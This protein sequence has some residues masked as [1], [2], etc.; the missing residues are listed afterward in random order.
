MAIKLNFEKKI[1]T[2]A[3][4]VYFAFTKKMGLREWIAD[5]VE[6]NEGR[7]NSFVL[8]WVDGNSVFGTIVEK[9]ENEKI[10]FEALTAE[11][12]KK[13]DVEILIEKKDDYTILKSEVKGVQEK[14]QDKVET[15]FEN[16]FENLRSVLEDGKDLRVYKKPM[17]GINIGELINPESAKR[18]N[19]PVE[20]GVVIPALV[21]GLG[22]KAAGIK[23][24]DII[25]EINET[26][27]IAYEDFSELAKAELGDV[28]KTVVYRGEDRLEIEVKLTSLPFPTIPATAQ[29]AAEALSKTYLKLEKKLDEILIGVSENAAE[30]RPAKGEWNT[31]EVISHLLLAS[32]D[33]FKWAA[34]M[35]S[36][37]EYYIGT[38]TMPEKLKSTIACYPTLKE[39]RSEL[40]RA[41]KEGVAFLSEISVDFTSRKNSFLRLSENTKQEKA[42]YEDHIN[43]IK[44]NLIQAGNIK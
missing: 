41:Q 31:K 43:Q 36:G 38:S 39:L 19:Y 27:I 5:I 1:K 21:E 18:N 3:E 11:K 40:V 26:K 14:D 6:F 4:Q 16:A 32:R 8:T 42:H 28:I 17:L 30:Y 10:L 7:S 44:N 25:S 29:D 20:Y 13:F 12:Y 9:E 34:S 23:P 33:L 35:V 22:A 15:F 24:G 2:K 37:N